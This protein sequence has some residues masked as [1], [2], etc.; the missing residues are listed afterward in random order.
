[1]KFQVRVEIEINLQFK[2]ADQLYT[3][4]STRHDPFFYSEDQPDPT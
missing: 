2:Q 1:M 4:N 3:T